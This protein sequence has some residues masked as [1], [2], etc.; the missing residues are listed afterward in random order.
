MRKKNSGFTLVELLVVIAVIALLAGLLFP[1]LAR[2]REG[3]RTK[4]CL[5][6]MKQLG[7]GLQQYV[8][9]NGRRYPGSGDFNA[10]GKGHGQWVSGIQATDPLTGEP[11]TLA[12]TANG[13][14]IAGRTASVEDGAIY[15]YVRSPTVYFCPSNADGRTKRLSYSMNCAISFLHDVKMSQPTDI[16]TL[17]DEEKCNDGYFYATDNAASGAYGTSTDAMTQTH[18]GG[19]NLLFAD[20]H[21]KFYRFDAFVL[22]DNN[23][24]TYGTQAKANKWAGGTKT[25]VPPSGTPRF[26]DPAF[27]PKGS[28]NPNLSISGTPG[29]DACFA[30]I[31]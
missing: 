29:R 27:G 30:S 14:Y 7:L 4:V 19:G 1:A 11:G 10:W 5:S 13:T 12:T 20:G 2:V 6:N 15:S 23:D 9:D 25:N 21:A 24:A 26:H 17:V 22:A 16:I 28:M 18:N 8:Q 3:G 31:P